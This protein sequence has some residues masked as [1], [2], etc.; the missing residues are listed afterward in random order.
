VCSAVGIKDEGSLSENL[1][2]LKDYWSTDP[3][4]ETPVFGK[5]MSHK[6]FEQIWWYLHFNNN[7][8]QPPSTSRLFKIEPLLD[9]F[10]QKFQTVYMPN[11]QLS[12]DESVIPWRVRLRMRT[13]NP[14]KLTSMAYF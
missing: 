9:F 2:N 14:G 7:E 8:L 1:K 11:Q 13:Y 6:K 3:F 5:L 4:L 10:I 12:L